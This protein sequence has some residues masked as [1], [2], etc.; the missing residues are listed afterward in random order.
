VPQD[1]RYDDGLLDMGDESHSAATYG[2]S[3]NINREQQP[4]VVFDEYTQ[5]LRRRS[6]SKSD[7]EVVLAKKK[8]E[9]RRLD[10]E[11]ERLLDLYQSGSITKREVE[12]RIEKLRSR[13]Q[14]SEDEQNLLRRDMDQNSQQCNSSNNSTR[15]RIGSPRGLIRLLSRR[16]RG[17][18]RL[19][20][21]KFDVISIA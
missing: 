3:R 13:I 8:K 2:A 1:L 21:T 18:V 10:Q 4:K 16:K 20:Q 6:K 19:S 17:S 11:K 5:R 9:T 7:L 14:K 12:S 15:S